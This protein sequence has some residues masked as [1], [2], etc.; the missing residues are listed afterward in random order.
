MATDRQQ[1]VQRHHIGRGRHAHHQRHSLW[2]GCS[3]RKEQWHYAE[4]SRFDSRKGDHISRHHHRSR[5]HHALRQDADIQGSSDSRQRNDREDVTLQGGRLLTL[6]S[7]Q[8][9]VHVI[10]HH[11]GQR[12]PRTRHDQRDLC[13]RPRQ[14]LHHLRLQALKRHGQVCENLSREAG[15]GI[16]VG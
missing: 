2:H 1:H 8:R 14:V 11:S 16:R 6:S 9:E 4:R 12:E 7:E 15:R 5:R 3:D 10:T 13:A